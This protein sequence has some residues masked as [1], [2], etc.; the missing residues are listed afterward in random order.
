M[1]G[2]ALR[3]AAAGVLL[4][5]GTTHARADSG[6][7]QARRNFPPLIQGANTRPADGAGPFAR[8]CPAAGSRLEQRGGPAFEHLGASPANSALCRMR[9][10]R[11]VGRSL[12]RHLGAG[13]ARRRRGLPGPDPADPGAHRRCRGVRRADGAWLA[14]ARPDP[15]P[16]GSRTSACWAR[17]Y[18]RHQAGA[19]PG[20][21]RPGNTYRSVATVWKD[22]D[23]GMIIYATYQHISGAPEID[24]P[25]I[26]TAIIPAR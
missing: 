2:A 21:V 17:P 5:V 24:D 14:M 8:A 9:G 7:E 18:P 3:L 4:L 11:P 23:S 12:V 10:R 13:L 19:L 16:R 6:L 1:L 25:L 22:L 26:P 20:G 15:Q